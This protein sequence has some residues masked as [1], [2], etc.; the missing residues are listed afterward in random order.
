MS[1]AHRFIM[2]IPNK[3][4]LQQ[5]A[6]NNSSGIKFQDF[7]NLYK[8]CTAKPY[9]FLVIDATLAQ[10]NHSCFK[11]NLLERIQKLIMTTDDK[12]RD[13]KL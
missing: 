2:K 3:Q 1:S 8:K 11:K 13:E 5:F 4:E 9:S 12:I 6:F 10:D 7:T